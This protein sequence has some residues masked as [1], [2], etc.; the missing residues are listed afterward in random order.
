MLSGFPIS[1]ISVQRLG[2]PILP[3]VI[4]AALITTIISTGNGYTFGASRLLHALALDGQAPK[5]LRR[6]NKKYE[7]SRISENT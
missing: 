4:N 3:S 7:L 2:I 1:V 6:L 5:F